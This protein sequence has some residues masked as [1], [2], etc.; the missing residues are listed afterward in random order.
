MPWTLLSSH[1]PVDCISKGAESRGFTGKAWKWFP[2]GLGVRKGPPGSPSLRAPRMHRSRG[3]EL[4]GAL[5]AFLE[6]ADALLQA[7]A[8]RRTAAAPSSPL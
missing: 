4:R 1:F 8:H 6:R 5:P 7:L 2:E 3:G